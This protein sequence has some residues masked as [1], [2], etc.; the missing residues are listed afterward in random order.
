M[1]LYDRKEDKMLDIKSRKGVFI[2]PDGSTH[3]FGINNYHITKRFTDTNV[4]EIAFDNEI[5]NTPWFQEVQ[6][7]LNF[8]T[9]D[10]KFYNLI[11]TMC[12]KGLVLILNVC[13][14]LPITN[15][16]LEK[17]IIYTPI[18]LTNEQE[19]TLTENYQELKSLE[20][21]E[22]NIMIK[23]IAFKDNGECTWE[24]DIQGIDNIY[25]FYNINRPSNKK[26]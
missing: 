19:Q 6:N 4:H 25:D 2:S 18:E 10:K 5:R 9:Q 3:P 12:G 26:R 20:E 16:L 14:E 11:D 1:I 21:Q 24:E 23:A 13:S 15:Q 22:D 17:Y 7:K 8:T